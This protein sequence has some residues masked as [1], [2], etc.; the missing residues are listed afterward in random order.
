MQT[1]KIFFSRD[2]IFFRFCLSKKKWIALV[3]SSISR[4]RDF[5]W[6]AGGMFGAQWVPLILVEPEHSIC[7]ATQVDIGISDW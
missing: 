7:V 1:K 2:S 6:G 3:T 5:E 4:G